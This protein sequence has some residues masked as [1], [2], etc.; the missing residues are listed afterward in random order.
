[1]RVKYLYVC[2]MYIVH[3]IEL[4]AVNLLSHKDIKRRHFI[5]FKKKVFL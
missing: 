3:N 4:T 5:K 2:T 1:V